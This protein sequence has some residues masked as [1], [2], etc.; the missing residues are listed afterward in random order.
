MTNILVINSSAL[1]ENSVSH[2]LTREFVRELQARNP[3][4]A[5]YSRDV[6]STPLPHVTPASVG[7]LRAAAPATDAERDARGLSDMLIGEV[8]AADL[9]V[10][11]SPMYNLGIAA[12]L[13]GW[14]DHILR[15]GRTFR[16][17]AA[18]PEGLLRGKRAIVIETRGGLYS[19]GPGVAMDAQEPHLRALL[20]FIGITDVTFVRAERLAIDPESRAAAIAAA[21]AQLRDLAGGRLAQA[22]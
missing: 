13:K 10:I 17:T 2:G 5:V 7:A 9:L 12:T 15:A 21:T 3:Q 4:A 11:G 20:G 16:Y 14:F 18:G 6:G 8:E 22:A 19:E 1:G